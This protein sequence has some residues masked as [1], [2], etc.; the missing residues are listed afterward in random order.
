MF[1]FRIELFLPALAVM[2]VAG[3]F[4][5]WWPLLKEAFHH[6]ARGESGYD[7]L[8]FGVTA[9]L[10]CIAGSVRRR[11]PNYAGAPP[12]GDVVRI[13]VPFIAV[14]LFAMTNALAAST[15]S[16]F[17]LPAQSGR[18]SALYAAGGMSLGVAAFCIYHIALIIVEYRR[19]LAWERR[20]HPNEHK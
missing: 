2:L 6:G 4:G 13:V 17:L 19:D 1:R 12:L 14:L 18:I 5:M 7:L 20:M 16:D 3:V 9:A 15:L 10:V 8:C 11:L